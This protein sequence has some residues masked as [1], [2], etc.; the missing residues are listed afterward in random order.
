MYGVTVNPVIALPASPVGAVQL[1]SALWD[2]GRASTSVGAAGATAAVGVTAPEGAES[3]PCPSAL[4]A[5][6]RNVYAVPAVSPEIVVC[7]AGGD[8]LTV[9][10]GCAVAPM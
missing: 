4:A 2:A 8:P 10:D 7:M 1:T 5:R 9:L 3:A 6:T